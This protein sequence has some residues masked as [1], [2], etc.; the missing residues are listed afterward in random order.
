MH[1][2]HPEPSAAQPSDPAASPPA[3]CR[4][5]PRPGSEER[6]L[7]MPDLDFRILG[8]EA[9]NYGIAPLLQF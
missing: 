7:T 6:E 4:G 2:R 9:A 3:K 8:V 1:E 5:L